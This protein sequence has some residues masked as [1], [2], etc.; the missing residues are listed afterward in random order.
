MCFA[1]MVIAQ[2][3]YFSRQYAFLIQKRRLFEK[4]LLFQ[5]L[6]FLEGFESRAP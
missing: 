2:N 5:R 1:D 6:L 3:K 4:I